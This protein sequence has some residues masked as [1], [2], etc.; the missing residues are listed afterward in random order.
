MHENAKQERPVWK[1]NEGAKFW[2]R[3]LLW[4][5]S[6]A[7]TTVDRRADAR[8]VKMGWIE[9]LGGQTQSGKLASLASLG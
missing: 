9:K 8:G 1:L 3:A 5:S 6:L 7:E 4:P 2:L